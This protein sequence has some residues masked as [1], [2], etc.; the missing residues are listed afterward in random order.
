MHGRQYV[1]ENKNETVMIS[2]SSLDPK[3]P[4][5][6]TNKDLV[7]KKEK[8]QNLPSKDLQDF[9]KSWLQDARYHGPNHP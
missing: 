2:I 9:L 7:R 4:I 5:I 1:H 6:K 3:N 8:S